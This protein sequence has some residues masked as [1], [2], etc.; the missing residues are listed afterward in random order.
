MITALSGGT[1]SIKLVRGLASLDEELVVIINVGDNTT[2]H[3]FYVAPDVDTVLYGLSG[4]LDEK[5]GWGIKGD[6]FNYLDQVNRLRGETWF[7]L[8]DR[9]IAIHALRTA[10]MRYGHSLSSVTANISERLGVNVKAIPASDEVIQTKIKIS[11]KEIPFQEYLVKRK[12]KDKVLGVKYDGDKRALPAPGVIDAIVSSECVVLCPANPITSIS[13][14]L[15]IPKVRKILKETSSK[16]VAVS[17]FI[18]ESPI[19]GPA[20]KLME[21][22]GLEVSSIGVARLYKDFLDAIVIDAKDEVFKD[23]IEALG[24]KVFLYDIVMSDRVDE[25]LLAKFVLR[26][27]RSLL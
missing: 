27:S 20:G 21:G 1:G 13:P 4:L 18:R 17:P 3:G 5:R 19:S 10:L 6:T 16:V 2:I 23:R 11:E 26:S 8:G 22:L 14:I 25:N 15:A 24:V 12:A 7:N 9:D